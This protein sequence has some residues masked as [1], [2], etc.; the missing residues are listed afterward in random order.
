MKSDNQNNQMIKMVA[1]PYGA[2]QP[3][4][5]FKGSG[6]FNF[7]MATIIFVWRRRVSS[8]ALPHQR[9]LGLSLELRRVHHTTSEGPE[10]VA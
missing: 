1:S 4:S 8:V 9:R 10:V 7:S 3:R 5:L 2:K 6:V